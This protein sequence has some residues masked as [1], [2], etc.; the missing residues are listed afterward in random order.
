MPK[1]SMKYEEMCVKYYAQE[2][3][4]EIQMKSTQKADKRRAKDLTNSRKNETKIK[5]TNARENS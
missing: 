5:H 2:K 4:R 3:I 1:T